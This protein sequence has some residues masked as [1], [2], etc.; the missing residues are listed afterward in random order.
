[1]LSSCP[2][3]PP[4]F[5]IWNDSESFDPV[6][7]SNFALKYSMSPFGITPAPTETDCIIRRN[8]TSF[9]VISLL[10]ANPTF[11]PLQYIDQ[12]GTLKILD[13]RLLL[14]RRAIR[15]KPS[16]ISRARAAVGTASSRRRSG[17]EAERL[18]SWRQKLTW[19]RRW[20]K[21]VPVTTTPVISEE[22]TDTVSLWSEGG[23]W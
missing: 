19:P 20:P 10:T 5:T 7:R 4:V 18:L 16:S 8:P 9:S 6:T 3:L 22:E 23:E 15:R 21:K 17:V 14:L 2:W 12:T 1:M 11:R 13:R